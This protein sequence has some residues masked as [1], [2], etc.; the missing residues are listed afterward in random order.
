V[1]KFREIRSSNSRVDSSFVNVWYDRCTSKT[2]T[3]QNGLNQNGHKR[4][5]PLTKTA[6]KW[7]QNGHIYLANEKSFGSHNFFTARR[8]A[9]RGICRHRVSVCLS[10]CLSV[11]V[12]V[13][14]CVSVTL[15]YC[16]KTAKRRIT[17]ITPHD[18]TLTLVFW[19]QSSLRNSK[20]ITSY[21]GREMQVGWVK[22]RHFRRKLRY[23]SKTVQDRH[24]V[25][26]KVE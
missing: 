3:Y 22:I 7:H 6:T 24:I 13:C 18:S 2:A 4:K 19:H 16:I 20:G 15:R 11:C 5:R 14:V 1:R 10:V 26:I 17:Q 8:L 23:N 25:S 9:K 21:G 12:C